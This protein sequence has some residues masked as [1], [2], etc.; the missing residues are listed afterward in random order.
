MA[1]VKLSVRQ[2]TAYPRPV[3]RLEAEALCNDDG[4]LTLRSW[5]VRSWIEERDDCLFFEPRS[6]TDTGWQRLDRPDD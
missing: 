3:N 5:K 6:I 2:R 4:W 1:G